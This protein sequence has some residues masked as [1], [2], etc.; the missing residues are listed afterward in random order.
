MYN[1][2]CKLNRVVQSIYAA[3]KYV[4]QKNFA[5]AYICKDFIKR[6][7]KK[8]IITFSKLFLY[9][10]ITDIIHFT[11]FSGNSNWRH[12]TSVPT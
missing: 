1:I 5:T 12:L 4:T 7:S 2:C 9:F 3:V 11:I 6:T 8:T 10:E